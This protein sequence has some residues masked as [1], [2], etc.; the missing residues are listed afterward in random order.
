MVKELRTQPALRTS[1]GAAH[2]STPTLRL[3]IVFHPD[4][5]RIGEW[6]DLC[7]WDP[8]RPDSLPAEVSLGRNTPLFS[9]GRAL[10]NSHISRLALIARP[11]LPRQPGARAS[12]RME[13]HEHADVRIGSNRHAMFIAD[14]DGLKSGIPLRLAHSV[15]LVLRWIP[16]SPPLDGAL[17]DQFAALLPGASP[18]IAQLW[19]DIALVAPT[20]LPVLILGE[21]GVGK[22]WVAQAIHACSERAQRPMVALNLA[23]VPEELAAAELFGS[24]RGAFTGALDR[25]GAFRRAHGGTLFLDEIV[26]APLTVQVQLLRALEQG[27]VQVLGGE[28]ARVDVRIIAAT[29]QPTDEEQGFRAALRHRV[30]GFSLSVPPLRNR[31]EDIAPQVMAMLA[32]QVAL[33]E[34]VDPQRSGEQPA[35]A[36]HWARFFFDALSREWS[37]NSRELRHAVALVAFGHNAPA[38]ITSGGE[39]LQAEKISSGISDEHL[40]RVHQAQNYEVSATAAVLGLSRPA[41]YRRLQAHPRC[42]LAEDLT[43]A[44]VM[45]AVQVAGS[46]KAAALHL[47]VSQHALRPR[48]RRL[49]IL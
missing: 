32:G 29:D 26:D 25:P 47:R 35:V 40:E 49:G 23:A 39:T 2:Y 10:E 16:D 48:L 17:R 42:V 20:L 33:N 41:L 14:H 1:P 8:E 6:V 46:I 37:G 18:E 9:D 38:P 22:E 19:R 11:G 31:P 13:A 44:Q 43:D 34:R 12:L 30:A 7:P 5:D 21:S 3:T 45:A 28:A 27:E 36:A 4:L 24:V 15:V